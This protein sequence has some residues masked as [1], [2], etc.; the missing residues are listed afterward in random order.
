M[1][2]LALAAT[3]VAIDV[4]ACVTNRSTLSGAFRCGPRTH[5]VAVTV[6]TAYMLAHLYGAIPADLDPLRRLAPDRGDNL[7]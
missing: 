1:P 6:A 2:W 5:P 3:I 4:H 7:A